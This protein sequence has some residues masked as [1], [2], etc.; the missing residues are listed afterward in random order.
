[1]GSGAR[2]SAALSWIEAVS[3]WMAT[4]G[5]EGVGDGGMMVDEVEGKI[6]VLPCVVSV[7][8]VLGSRVMDRLME[9][10]GRRPPP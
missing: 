4:G 7:R 1:M 2:S 3:V 8:R 6:L 9:S 5:T 10:G